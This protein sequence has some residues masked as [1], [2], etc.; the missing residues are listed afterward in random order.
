MPILL[1]L[2][3]ILALAQDVSSEKYCF[4][5]EREAMSAKRKFEAIQVPSDKVSDDGNCLVVTMSSHRR[6]LIQR[7][8]RS[9]YPH[10]QI[11]FS[12]E[13]LQTEPCRLKVE[14]EK[15]KTS[16]NISVNMQNHFPSADANE[17]R[18]TGTDILQIETLKNFALSVDQDEIRGSCRYITPNRYEI[19]LEVRKTPKPL[20]PP[21]PAGTVVVLTNP[22]PPPD[23]ETMFLKTTLQINR[24]ER[25]DIGTIVKDLRNKETSVDISPSLKIESKDQDS[26]EKVFLSLQ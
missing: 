20:L 15:W 9:S 18:L 13:E 21:V 24:G 23:Q 5:S 17:A 11:S 14:K 6:E 7:Y 25:I 26:S 16:K 10:V 1:L 22:V 3:S 12:S 4:T 8:F 2:S 19:D